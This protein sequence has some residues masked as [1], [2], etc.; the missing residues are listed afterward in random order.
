MSARSPLTLLLLL[1]ALGS[2][3]ATTD[4]AARRGTT[5]SG[6]GTQPE[7]NEPLP[8]DETARAGH[9]LFDTACG[10]CHNPEG[11]APSVANLRL[12]RAR[13]EQVLH[14]GSDRGDLMPVLRPGDLRREDLPALLAY[15]R[16]VRAT[17]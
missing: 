15:L 13:M 1:G 4:G 16:T 17:E 14:A 6:T 10:R 8:E 3:C 5:G 12:P 11:S 9:A 7:D 2:T